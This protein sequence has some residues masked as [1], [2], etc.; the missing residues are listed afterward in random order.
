MV[1]LRL[2]TETK[3]YHESVEQFAHSNKIMDHTLSLDQYRELIISQY[4]LHQALEDRMA[5]VLSPAQKTELEFDQ[6]RKI[7]FLAQDMGLVAPDSLHENAAEL[8][9][10]YQITDL[11]D[12][13]GAMYV[14]EGSTLGGAVIRRELAKNP[15]IANQV[16]DFHYYGCYGSLI[17]ERWKNFLGLLNAWADT[18]EKQDAVVQKAKDTFK[19][20]ERL[21]AQRQAVVA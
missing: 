12:A 5:Q 1:A 19:L 20:F 18:D 6:R 16:A 11:Y 3:P 17:G 4:Q 9:A 2:K 10:Q 7:D 14:L 15:N 8:V 21:L 13:L